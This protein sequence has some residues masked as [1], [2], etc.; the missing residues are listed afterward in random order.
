MANK[1]QAIDEDSPFDEVADDTAL[2]SRVVER[3]LR[4]VS[5]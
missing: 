3:N 2:D 1:A 4:K 5:R